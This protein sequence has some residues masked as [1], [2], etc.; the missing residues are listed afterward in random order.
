MSHPLCQAIA[1]RVPV[2]KDAGRFFSAVFF[3]GM[4]WI[5]VADE[6]LSAE[7]AEGERGPLFSTESG[8]LTI[9]GVGPGNP[10][11]YD[12][13][14][15]LDVIDAAY[16]AAE[17][18]LGRLDLRGFIVTRDMWQDPPDQYSLEDGVRDFEE[19]RELA[20][21]S[22]LTT[23]PG[24]VAGAGDRMVRPDSGRIDDTRY[25]SSPGSE[26]IVTE[27][28]RATPEKPLVV[29]VGGAPTTVATALLQEPKIAQRMVVLWLAIRQ[30]NANDEWA[31][32]VML[33]RAPVVHYDFK[34][35]DGLTAEM[36]E[37]LPD[38]PICRRFRRSALVLD[39]G[40]GDGVL[41][42]WMLDNRLIHDAEPQKLNGLLDYGPTDATRYSFLHV[43]N[44]HKRSG[45][46]AQAM[47]DVLRDPRVWESGAAGQ[48]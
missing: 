29:V 47:I 22:G 46:I 36:L 20:I 12:N 27:A 18:K 37:S 25:L 24:H 35:R 5:V 10:V 28:W 42:A 40:V 14:W 23:V 3:T 43:P 32:H 13:D 44:R 31:S 4:L 21:R 30:Y 26:L 11:I 2:A 16:C 9:P 33:R 1:R 17:H 45:A 41:L 38:N 6:A 48:P 34:L 15:W 7:R 39:N 19:F 8:H